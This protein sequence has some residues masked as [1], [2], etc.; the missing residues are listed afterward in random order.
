M[1]TVPLAGLI[2]RATSSTTIPPIQTIALVSCSV[3]S[4][5]LNSLVDPHLDDIVDSLVL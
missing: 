2:L 3:I 4:L 1:A 5:L